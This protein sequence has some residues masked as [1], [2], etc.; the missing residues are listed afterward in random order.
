[1]ENN[2]G[3]RNQSYQRDWNANDQNYAQNRDYENR[4]QRSDYGYGVNQNYN[5]GWQNRGSGGYNDQYEGQQR[6]YEDVNRRSS[7]GDYDQNNWRNSDW[8]NRN[9]NRNFDQGNYNDY[10]NRHER[11]WWDR[12]S[13]EVASWFGNDEAERRRQMDKMYG[14]HRG[15]GPKGY[16]RSDDRIAEDINEKLYHDSYV[17]A[18]NIE[19]KVSNG[20]VILS[21]T[22]ESRDTKHRAEDIADAVT[23]V[24]NVQNQLKVST[25]ANIYDKPVTSESE[26]N[27]KRSSLAS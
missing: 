22:V 14:P 13:D 2:N 8:Q 24:K 19:V 27:R 9:P 20:E 3:N 12:T 7:M 4:N 1:M 17:D 25:G 5:Q 6:H 21:G 26:N 10:R 23:G 18:S 15:K 16:T 11:N